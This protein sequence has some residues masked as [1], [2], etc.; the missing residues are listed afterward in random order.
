MA[1]AG[2]VLI[3]FDLH[4]PVLFRGVHGAGFGFP[5]LDKAQRL[6]IGT[7]NQNLI[8]RQRGLRNAVTGLDQ[9][10]VFGFSVVLTPVTRLKKLRIDTA[11]V[12]SSAL[13]DDLQ[14][15][16]FANHAGGDLNT[17]GAPAVG[18]RHFAAAE[19]HGSRGSPQP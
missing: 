13:V 2:D 12:V 3:Q 9:R 11:L 7:E 1:E 6:R 15:V 17:A 10:R 4:D 18:H 19:R 8:F 5:R 16:R 14:H